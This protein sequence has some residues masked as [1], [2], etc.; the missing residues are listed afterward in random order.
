MENIHKSLAEVK[1]VAVHDGKFHADE[2]FAIAALRLF[3]PGLEVIRTRDSKEHKQVDLR[4]DVCG[5][6][7]PN[8]G[9]YDHH[10]VNGPKRE[11]G[12]PYASFGMIWKHY[13]SQICEKLLG[14]AGKE[15]LARIVL[16]V[17][18]I[19][20]QKIDADDTGYFSPNENSKDSPYLLPRF[21]SV[22][23]PQWHESGSID[24]MFNESVDIAKR[25]LSREIIRAHS[26]ILARSIII[27]ALDKYK[28]KGYFVL[29]GTYPWHEVVIEQSLDTKF[30]VHKGS[31]SKQWAVTC[32]PAEL[33]TY[34]YRKKLPL[35]WA[36]LRDEQLQ[37]LTGVK[38][39]LFCH[40]GR[41]TAGAISR[42][43]AIKLAE[44]ALESKE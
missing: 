3:N 35:V 32:V 7:E 6:Y 18:A 42:E 29:E 39:A 12:I 9:D 19:L 33:G 36:G 43:G 30:L 11:N 23:N 26:V 27:D 20:V 25:I 37:N 44:L 40:N 14:N 28:G 15:D 8:K 1:S 10:L 5:R 34:N 24:M 41:F 21:F 38:D 4:V 13:G 22:L 16:D 31:N 17:D 2:A